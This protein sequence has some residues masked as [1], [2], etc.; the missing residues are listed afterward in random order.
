MVYTAV[1]QQQQ[2]GYWSHLAYGR[3][4]AVTLSWGHIGWC[5]VFVI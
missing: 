4:D 2:T 1:Y 5:V 3:M